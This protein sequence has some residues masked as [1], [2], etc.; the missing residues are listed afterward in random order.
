ML[1]ATTLLEEYYLP[2]TKA[3]NILLQHSQAV[4]K[5]SVNIATRLLNSDNHRYADI[6]INFI[7]QAALLHDIG[8]FATYAPNLGCYGTQPYLRHGIVG[9]AVLL[10]HGLPRHASVCQNHIGVGLS[11]AEIKEQNLPLP[12]QDYL[13]QNLAEQ[14]IT[15]ADLFFSK[16]PSRLQQEKSAATVRRTVLSYGAEKG[17]V[18]DRWHAVFAPPE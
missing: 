17:L 11:A 5:K 9:H 7:R 6:D 13:P 2:H 10:E 18:F 4:A 3:H 12:E 8:I 15:Y 1:D 16:N 14:I